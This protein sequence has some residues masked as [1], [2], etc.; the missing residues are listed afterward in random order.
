MA[1]ANI[2]YKDLIDKYLEGEDQVLQLL[3]QSDREKKKVIRTKKMENDI[4]T[5][6]QLVLQLQ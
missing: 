6:L 3:R 1:L 2:Y 5:H 4:L